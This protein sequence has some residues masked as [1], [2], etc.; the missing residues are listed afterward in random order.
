MSGFKVQMLTTPGVRKDQQDDQELGEDATGF[1]VKDDYVV[2]WVADGAPGTKV[3]FKG[4]NFGSRVLAKYMGEAFET[5]ALKSYT[6]GN[7]FDDAFLDE[8][9]AELRK[10]LSTRLSNIHTQLS[11]LK[12]QVDLDDALE[13]KFDGNQKSYGLTW[14]ATFVGALV[15]MKNNVCYTMSI[16]DCIALSDGTVTLRYEPPPPIPEPPAPVIV[17]VVAPVDAPHVL[18]LTKKPAPIMV[19]TIPLPP[20]DR[21]EVTKWIFPP[22]RPKA[23][24]PVKRTAKEQTLRAMFSIMDVTNEVSNSIVDETVKLSKNGYNSVSKKIAVYSDGVF[25]KMDKALEWL[26][27]ASVDAINITIKFIDISIKACDKFL[28]KVLDDII[29]LGVQ[30]VYY[31]KIKAQK[32]AARLLEEAKKLRK[33]EE[34]KRLAA[35]KAAEEEAKKVAEAEAK[36]AAIAAT[37]STMIEE[38]FGEPK[39]KIITGRANRMFVLWSTNEALDTFEVTDTVNSP[40]FGEIE[41]VKSIILMSDG[42]IP[43][44]EIE[45]KFGY[46]DPD[47]VWDELRSTNNATDDDKTAIYFKILGQN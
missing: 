46:K 37:P 26:G 15:D 47:N 32:E 33:A 3:G 35:A 25:K 29:D 20:V 9:T 14:T 6:P 43:Y 40:C 4:Y 17:P 13:V 38:V 8:F 34:A 1:L 12:D 24:K 31:K 42:V 44:N 18:D 10:Q 16:G 39:L 28:N 21:V 41:D 30:I 23:A 11:Q 2:L 27:D 22:I 36:A 7:P 19:N 45:C 5:V